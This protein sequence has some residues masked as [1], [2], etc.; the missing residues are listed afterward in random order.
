MAVK[1]E[2]VYRESWAADWMNVL[3]KSAS[4]TVA[5]TALLLTKEV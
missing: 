4:R 3:K 5:L 2:M 1:L